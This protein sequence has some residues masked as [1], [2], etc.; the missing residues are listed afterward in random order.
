[1]KWKT[2]VCD[3]VVFVTI[4]IP[5]VMALQVNGEFARYNK[6]GKNPEADTC[7]RGIGTRYG[8]RCNCKYDRGVFW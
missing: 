4:D 5:G 3:M 2:S 6:Q 7:K 8:F 1:M